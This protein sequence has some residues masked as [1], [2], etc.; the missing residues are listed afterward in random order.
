MTETEAN[1][2]AEPRNIAW[3]A[4]LTYTALGLG[5]IVSALEYD[6]VSAIADPKAILVTTAIIFLFFFV[7]I[8]QVQRGRGWARWA[9]LVLFV[10][11]IPFYLPQVSDLLERNPTAGGLSLL[12]FVLQIAAL[13]LVFTGEARAYFAKRR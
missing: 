4:R 12:Q 10:I 5:I 7:L 9:Y 2:H 13:V 8:W 3:F 11:G 6:H 1:R